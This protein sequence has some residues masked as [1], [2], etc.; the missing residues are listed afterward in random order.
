MFKWLNSPPQVYFICKMTG[1]YCDDMRL[2]ADHDSKILQAHNIIVHHPIIKEGI[3]K[4]HEMLKDRS[5]K[6][7]D[8][9]W[10][11]DKKAIKWAS[12]IIDSAAGLYSTGA[13]REFGKGRYRDWTPTVTLWDKG[14]HP[15]F[16]ARQEDDI[17]VTTVEE[18]AST[19]QK[20][21]GTRLKRMAWKFPIYLANWHDISLYKIWRF[22]K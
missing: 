11:G 1:L 16:I 22:F 13:K 12:V 7:M 4:V 3:P 8:H 15:P 20:L 9:L 21:W 14:V 19:I 6:E 10:N 5:E 2:K 18:A 17:C